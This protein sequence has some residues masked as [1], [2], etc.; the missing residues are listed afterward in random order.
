MGKNR[1]TRKT[2]Q[3]TLAEQLGS[4][5]AQMLFER[6]DGKGQADCLVLVTADGN[7][8]GGWAESAAAK[9]IASNIASKLELTLQQMREELLMVRRQARKDSA[10]AEDA[11]QYERWLLEIGKSIGCSHLDEQLPNCVIRALQND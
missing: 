3:Q 11:D 2:T 8:H 6:G 4:E 10:R 5:V 1:K 7:E 9:A